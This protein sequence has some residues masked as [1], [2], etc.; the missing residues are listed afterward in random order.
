MMSYRPRAIEIK[1]GNEVRISILDS[2]TNP[3][4]VVA[5]RVWKERDG[6][7]YRQEEEYLRIELDD[8]E[9]P[10]APSTMVGTPI[11]MKTIWPLYNRSY[12][13]WRRDL[14][15]DT[16]VFHKFTDVPYFDVG[17]VELAL[18][19]CGLLTPLQDEVQREQWHTARE[20][21]INKMVGSARHPNLLPFL[22]C[23]VED[24][25]VAS[26]V[27]PFLYWTL[28]DAVCHV[29]RKKVPSRQFKFTY[30]SPTSRHVRFTRNDEMTDRRRHCEEDDYVEIST[31]IRS[32]NNAMKYII[33]AVAYL[34]DTYQLCYLNLAPH[35]IMY[36]QAND[37]WVIVGLGECHKEGTRFVDWIPG[38][39]GW[40]QNS[41]TVT[42]EI[43]QSMLVEIQKYIKT[44]AHPKTVPR[45]E[46]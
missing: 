37:K 20:I 22:G 7:F 34:R 26:L 41:Q 5:V 28:E 15:C 25:R 38:P 45:F 10:G 17:G 43:V 14:N 2:P 39:V 12:P 3:Q 8:D 24:G 6:R 9:D 4:R 1:E 18:V 16:P 42:W 35:N 23:E 13:K 32:L 31:P 46:L 33:A 27:F 11:D 40:A 30:V 36:N 44:G 21:H 19:C 29:F